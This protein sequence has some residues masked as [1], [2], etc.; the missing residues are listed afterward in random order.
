MVPA[1]YVADPV[2]GVT[3]AH[4]MAH[5]QIVGVIFLVLPQFLQNCLFAQGRKPCFDSYHCD[6]YD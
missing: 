6:I 5:S 2:D 4:K 3:C 1:A